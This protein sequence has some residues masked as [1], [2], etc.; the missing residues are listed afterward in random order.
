[1]NG[2]NPQLIKAKINNELREFEGHPSILEACRAVGIDIP[3][4][5]HDERLKAIGSCRMCLVKVEG[6]PHPMTACNTILADGMEISTH[7]AALENERRA[8][9]KMLAQDH[10]GDGLM[11]APE[12]PFYQYAL[13]YG[14]TESDFNGSHE[15]KLLDDSHPYIHVDMSQCIVCY[16][17]VRIC[18]EVQGQFV[19]Q[20]LNR[21]HETRIVPDS[22]TTLLE[23]SCVG[24]GAC[25]DTCPSGA[26]EDKSML[27]HKSPTNWMRTTCPY[28]G[29]GCEMSVGTRQ[30]Q[31][32]SIKPLLEAPVSLGHLC[33][34]GRYAFN[35]V[36]AADR[37]TEPMIRNNN[38]WLQVTWDE[39]I[40]FTAR[41]LQQILEEHG[42]DSIGILGSARGTNE[43]AYLAQK[44]ARVVIG[45]NNVD[46]CARV[47]HT[48]TAAAMKLMIGTGAATNSYNDIEKAQAILICGANATENH[49]IVGAR[50]KQA[51]LRGANLI[52]IDPRKI[53]LAQY[54]VIHLQPRPGTNIPLLNALAYTIVE[55]QLFDAQ[56]ANERVSE[57]DEFREFVNQ[58]APEQ[59]QPICGVTADLIR[60]AA[61]LYATSK[62][63][64]CFHGLGVTEHTQ[65]TEGVMCLVN[66]ALLTGN[67]GKPGTG[68]N[69]LRGQ[70][71]VQGAAHMG[72]DPGILT[73]S[74]SLN[75]A[76]PLFE[77]VWNAPVPHDH[78]LNMLEMMDAAESGKLKA[79]WPIGYDVALTNAN[80]AATE[81]ALRS[82]DLV[83][84]QDLFLNETARQ[85]GSVFLP[86][87]SS[88][89]RDG[90]FMNAERGIQRIRKAIEPVGHSMPDWEIIC[91]VAHAMGKGDFFS[92]NSAE[93]IWNEIRAVWPAGRG[94][95][96]KR[97]DDGGLQW[98]CPDEDHP[99]TE[100][101][102]TES[103]PIG[104]KAALR[105]I[106]YRPTREVTS[107]NFPFLLI[108]GRA[109]YQFNAGTM[110]MR[111]ANAELRATD[112][113]DISAED[114][115]R[116]NL[117]NGERVRVHSAYGQAVLPIRITPSVKPGELFATFHTTEVSLNRVTSPRRDRH[118]KTPEYKITAARIEKAEL[119]EGG[120]GET[121]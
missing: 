66:L 96:Y 32:V 43:E 104:K 61:R 60:Q 10:P 23:S 55:E 111:T 85:F 58:F 81:R 3:T 59:V 106:P 93:E 89:E 98:P 118:V 46:C 17:C 112:L 40:S 79:L 76:R 42:P 50:I 69:P 5:C 14:L 115:N 74:V 92:H 105:R 11:Q 1:M 103:F 37:I 39:A 16:R 65:G 4:L 113:L 34:K 116:L 80:T 31:I 35:F 47:C 62:P 84:V 53:E 71:N 70:N 95:T 13:Q 73:G 48:P 101:L 29:T 24:C 64:M 27:A 44:F 110:T 30:N 6:K 109:L 26:L 75:D 72:C 77:S 57:W 82:L 99:G 100:I 28:C 87:A 38:G 68:I 25:V 20:I 33:I 107:D 19:W 18:E 9:L 94:V 2:T 15:P 51:A 117:H 120:K 21:G 45:T 22:G 54:A 52:V 78:G 7:T 121:R 49:P 119:L 91:A 86:A 56:F 12:K 67:I 114:A 108:T 63:S 83:I 97:L 41:R 90:T 102:H 36:H 88:F 8:L